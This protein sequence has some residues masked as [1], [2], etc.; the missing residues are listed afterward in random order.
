MNHSCEPNLVM[1]TIRSSSM[2]PHLALFTIRDVAEVTFVTCA[3][4]NT[5][6]P[7]QGEELCFDYGGSQARETN[8]SDLDQTGRTVCLC[9]ANSCKGYLP[10]NP[11]IN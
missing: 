11:G 2:V 10:Y 9:G 5:E 1:V 4:D 8:N 7:C 6:E 3:G